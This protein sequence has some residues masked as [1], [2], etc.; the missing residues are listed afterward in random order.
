MRLFVPII[1]AQRLESASLILWVLSHET[2]VLRCSGAEGLGLLPEE[3]PSRRTVIFIL[4][5][6]GKE[7]KE[8][9]MLSCLTMVV[10]S[11]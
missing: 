4:P 9:L 5:F 8:K 3:N 7:R 2:V 6:S 11:E 10:I 1:C